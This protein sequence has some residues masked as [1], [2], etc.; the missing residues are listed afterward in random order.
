VTKTSTGCTAVNTATLTDPPPIVISSAVTNITCFGLTN[1]SIKGTVTGGTGTKTYLWNTGATVLTISNL[2]AGAY[3]LVVTDSKG[4][5]ASATATVVEP[6]EVVLTHIEELLTNGN[7]KITLSATGGTPYP[8]GL[9]HRYC[10]LSPTNTCTFGSTKIYTNLPPGSMYTFRAKDYKSCQD[11]IMVT[12][13]PAKP[14]AAA[15]EKAGLS[16]QNIENQPI[17]LSPNPFYN[18]I[19]LARDADFSEKL[20]VK[21][22]DLNGRE[23]VGQVWPA[24]SEKLEIQTE[25]L[26]AGVY[27]IKIMG[28][29][30]AICEALRAVKTE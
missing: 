5:T 25:R 10:K 28:E 4:C 2:A 16:F 14:A 15:R 7:Y 27:F 24:D 11:E 12:L 19:K 3:T 23:V 20:E 9:P 18:M 29:N 26:A 1:G 30:G 8:T 6:T 13:P 22:F 17:A 21:I